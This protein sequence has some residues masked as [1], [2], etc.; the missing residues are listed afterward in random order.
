MNGGPSKPAVEAM[1]RLISSRVSY[2][3]PVAIDE[4]D[5]LAA[6]HDPALGLDRSVCLRDVV[7]ALHEYESASQAS[8]T[9]DEF[10]E[11]R[12]GRTEA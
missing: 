4:A 8:L 5:L 12:F 2:D 7:D 10:V 3:E 11:M 9:A 1:A 6:A